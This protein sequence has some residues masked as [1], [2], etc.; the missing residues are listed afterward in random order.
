MG[1]RREREGAESD[2]TGRAAAPGEAGAD[3]GEGE[4]CS[5]EGESDEE[6]RS[7]LSGTM[8]MQQVQAELLSNFQDRLQLR[9]SLLELN[10]TTKQNQKEVV[11]LAEQQTALRAESTD[12]QG[13]VELLRLE[14][15]A[16]SLL[17]NEAQNEELRASL[18]ER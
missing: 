9:R 18:A 15:D 2:L 13:E 10:E 5:D 14:A 6:E 4:Y 3:R 12:G 11:S 1:G 8:H 16:L 17:R 7:L